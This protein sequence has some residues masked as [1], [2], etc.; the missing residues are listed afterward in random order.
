VGH[1]RWRLEKTT[2]HGHLVDWGIHLVDAVRVI[3]GESVPRQVTA[4]GG[5]YYLK[6]KITTPDTLMVHFEFERCP[7]VWRHRIWGAEEYAPE[8][9]NGLFFFGDKATVFATDGRWVVIPNGKAA[10]RKEF[11]TVSNAGLAHMADFLQ[12]V[13]SRKQ[14]SCLIE[15]AFQSTTTVQLGMIAYESG[16]TVRWDAASEQIPGNPAAAALLK[17]DYRGPWTHPYRG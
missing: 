5:L 12:A 9:N 17:R 3:L 6:D 16:S 1:V 11:K 8:A 15:D 4:A 14:P 2:G 10:D 13:R 7:L